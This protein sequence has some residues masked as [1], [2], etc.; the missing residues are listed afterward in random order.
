VLCWK[1]G[2]LDERGSDARFESEKAQMAATKKAATKKS[3]I[4]LINQTTSTKSKAVHTNTSSPVAATKIVAARAIALKAAHLKTAKAA[5][6][7]TA[8]AAPLKTAKAAPLK[9]AR[10]AGSLL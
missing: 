7:K 1:W 3:V 2:T 6:L 9:T 5:P 10:T 4:K 8:K